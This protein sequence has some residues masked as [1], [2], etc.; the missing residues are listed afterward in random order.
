MNKRSGRDEVVDISEGYKGRF[1]STVTGVRGEVRSAFL[2]Q[3]TLRTL[4]GGGGVAHM[5]RSTARDRYEED[6]P[7]TGTDGGRR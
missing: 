7:R 4:A 5:G 6:Q 3:D 2:D 1:E